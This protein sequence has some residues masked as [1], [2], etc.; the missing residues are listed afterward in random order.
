MGH[1][2][3]T[4]RQ[5]HARLIGASSLGVADRQSLAFVML[6]RFALVRMLSLW[7]SVGAFTP[8]PSWPFEYW[9]GVL[10]SNFSE[11]LFLGKDQSSSNRRSP[12]V[13]FKW[14]NRFT[15]TIAG[16]TLVRLSCRLSRRFDSPP[17]PPL[18]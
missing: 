14:P 10:T 11:G 8:S 18:P 5:R 15:L 7:W 17:Q 6:G 9:C 16:N 4:T 12:K 2:G 1:D 3:D 13:Q